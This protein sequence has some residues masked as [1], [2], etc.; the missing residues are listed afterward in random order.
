MEKYKINGKLINIT[1][2]FVIIFLLCQTSPLWAGI[3]NKFISILAPFALAFA[4]SYACYPFLK[5]MVEKKIPRGLGVFIIVALVVGFI[6]LMICLVI[7]I[8]TEQLVA[9]FNMCIKYVQD[10]SLEYGIDLKF[11][12]KDLSNA[13]SIISSFGESIGNISL[14]VISTTMHI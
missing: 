1:L 9:L 12:Q 4:L 11:I 6:T 14:A 10:V 8:L 5:K 3:I 7:P 2:I 13:T